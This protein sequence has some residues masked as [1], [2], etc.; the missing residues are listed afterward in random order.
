[1]NASENQKLVNHNVNLWYLRR[2]CSPASIRQ[3]CAVCIM[4]LYTGNICANLDTIQAPETSFSSSFQSWACKPLS[5]AFPSSVNSGRP[6]GAID[7]LKNRGRHALPSFSRCVAFSRCRSSSSCFSFVACVYCLLRMAAVTP[8]QKRRDSLDNCCSSGGMIFG[9][10]QRG[11]R[12][13]R[14]SES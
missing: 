8:C 3:K 2:A 1:M 5:A 13:I 11:L 9:V 6:S 10:G 12:S 14:R 4:S 7:S